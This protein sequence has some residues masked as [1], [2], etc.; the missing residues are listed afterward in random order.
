MGD[1]PWVSFVVPFAVP[2]ASAVFMVFGDGEPLVRVVVSPFVFEAEF[3]TV[4]GVSF[5]GAPVFDVVWSEG[6]G[7][8]GRAVGFGFLDVE[9][10]DFGGESVGFELGFEVVSGESVGFLFGGDSGV[11]DSV[12]GGGVGEG[13]V[14]AFSFWFGVVEC[15]GYVDVF[16]ASPVV[17]SGGEG[18]GVGGGCHLGASYTLCT[19][20]SVIKIVVLT[21]SS[22]IS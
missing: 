19:W 20:G 9:V 13:D 6:A 12:D 14:R 4:F 21:Y 2:F 1:G 17:V 22:F 3:L 18:D 10:G 5:V 7:V 11:A 16:A 8:D 15:I